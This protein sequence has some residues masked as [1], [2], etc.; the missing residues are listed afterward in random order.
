MQ[1][2]KLKNADDFASFN[3]FFTRELEDG[4]RTFSDQENGI[5]SPADGAVSQIGDIKD[6]RIFQAKGQDYSLL[7][8]LGGDKALSKEFEDGVF[9]T[10]YLSPRDYHRVQDRKSVV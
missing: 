7:E 10:I 5:L 3:E 2:A 9:N 1:E 6:G 8:L 4:A